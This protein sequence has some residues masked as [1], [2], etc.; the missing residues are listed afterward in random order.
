LSWL[1]K[2]DARAAKWPA[3]VRWSYL[4]LKWGLFGLG[5]VLWLTLWF[6]RQFW[7]GVAQFV[8]LG[9]LAWQHFM[10]SPA[11]SDPAARR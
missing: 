8:V 7:L 4:V 6:E 5:A 9:Y 2:L 3:A 11:S 1:A 10:A